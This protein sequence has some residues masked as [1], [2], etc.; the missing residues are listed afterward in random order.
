M[1]N[2]NRRRHELKKAREGRRAIIIMI[3]TAVIIFGGYFLISTY[4]KS[5]GQAVRAE[6][7]IE[8]YIRSRTSEQQVSPGHEPVALYY[9]RKDMQKEGF[10]CVGTI[11]YDKMYGMIVV[12]AEHVF[13]TDLFGAQQISIRP[14]RKG[15][16]VP[17]YYFDHIVKTSSEL[18]NQDVVMATFGTIPKMFD[19]F[20]KYVFREMSKHF[21]GDI[22]IRDLKV[23][24]MRSL[25]SGERIATFGYGRRGEH[26][27]DPVFILI[28]YHSRLGE[29]GT[30]FIDDN[31]G[32]W[33]L[34]ATPEAGQEQLIIAEYEKLMN[35]RI[36]A[37][38]AVSGPFGGKYN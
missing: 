20:S 2:P 22:T 4:E 9:K 6:Q 27:N 12:T 3:A 34:H 13:R 10:C 14:L 36:K 30:G 8:S 29:S 15:V 21:Y 7:D 32:L 23:P 19:P 11:T 35:K 24:S 18:N 28:E 26:T 25:V 1:K 17:V 38:S 16:N 5:P 31:G 33:V 37:A